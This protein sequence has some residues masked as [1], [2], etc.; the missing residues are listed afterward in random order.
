MHTLPQQKYLERTERHIIFIIRITCVAMLSA[1]LIPWKLYISTDRVFEAAPLFSTLAPLPL[2]AEQILLGLSIGALAWLF[3]RPDK[4]PALSLLLATVLIGIVYDANRFQPYTLMYLATL[5]FAV[6]GNMS[7]QSRLIALKIMVCGIYFWAGFHK[8]NVTFISEILPWFISPIYSYSA[9]GKDALTFIDFA[10][11][12]FIIITPVYE[13]LIG[14]LLLIPKYRRIATMMAFGM[15]TVVLLCLGPLGHNWGMVV[16]PWNLHLFALELTLFWRAYDEPGWFKFSA[17]N[18]FGKASVVI[19]ALAPAIAM[20]SN[21]YVK[22]G[23]KLY[24]GNVVWATISFPP[25]ET[26]AKTPEMPKSLIK[27]HTLDVATWSV[28]EIE[29]APYQT[30]YVLR[31]SSS[32]LCKFLDKPNDAV[33]RVYDPAP[34]YTRKSEYSDYGLCN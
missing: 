1:F 3:I 12:M 16:W 29:S 27:D 22:P 23:Y 32:G 8:M 15:L 6:Y 14:I 13:L 11:S 18:L 21:A 19:F 5:V 34:F 25:E 9:V 26:F 17:I 28:K 10:M 33:I 7:L 30:S 20:F 2:Q 24:S 31:K 4:K